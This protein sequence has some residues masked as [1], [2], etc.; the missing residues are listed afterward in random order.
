MVWLIGCENR[1]LVID[2]LCDE[3]DEDDI[4]VTCFYFDF[5][6]RSEQSPTNMLGSLLRQVVSGLEEIPKAVVQGFRNEKR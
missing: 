4:A 1:S 5:A 2:R 6:A 3:A